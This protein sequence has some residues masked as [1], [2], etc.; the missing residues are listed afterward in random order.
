MVGDRRK[1][2]KNRSIQIEPA[3][4]ATQLAKGIGGDFGFADLPASVGGKSKRGSLV[5]AALDQFFGHFEAFVGVA[6]RAPQT[7]SLPFRQISGILEQLSGFV[8]FS[9]AHQ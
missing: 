9:L 1:P 4:N 5:R 8:S 7:R 3:G 2:R 6:K